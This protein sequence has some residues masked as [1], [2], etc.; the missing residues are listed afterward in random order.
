M[1]D[2]MALLREFYAPSS[3]ASPGFVGME[4]CESLFTH[5]KNK[6]IVTEKYLVRHFRSTQQFIEGGDLDNVYWIPGTG[7]PADGLTKTRTE[8]GP[9]LALLATGRFQPG[10]LRPLKGLASRECPGP[11]LPPP[12]P[13]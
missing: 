5:L 7:N 12:T 1:I 4:D 8:M 3:R 2:H 6:E 13:C 9:I 10:L 11:V